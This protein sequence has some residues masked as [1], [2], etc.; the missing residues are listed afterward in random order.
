MNIP[1]VINSHKQ[2]I[3]ITI[4]VLLDSIQKYNKNN[5]ICVI[6]GGYDEY[7]LTKE[8]GYLFIKVE[9]NSIDFTG[10][11]TL[12]EHTIEEITHTFFYIHDTCVVGPLFFEYVNNLNTDNKMHTI[13]LPLPSMNIGLYSI[14]IINYY[15]IK[16]MT[17]KN[18]DHSYTSIQYFK[19]KCIAEEGIIFKMNKHNHTFINTKVTVSNP[20]DYYGTN[21][22]RIIEYYNVIDLYKIKANW[23]VK[24]VYE[25]TP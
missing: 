2:N 4:P 23:H 16:L 22:L 10:L 20:T 12:L 21:V 25:L 14:D 1:I 18:T 24:N 13:S 7:S 6:A 15:R 11:I 9:H 19:T 3:G 17:F 8:S 5:V